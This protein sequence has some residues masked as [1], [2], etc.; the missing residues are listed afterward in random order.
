LL[1]HSILTAML[2][3]DWREEAFLEGVRHGVEL[4]E[5][6]KGLFAE[7]FQFRVRSILDIRLYE[8]GPS[9]LSGL[10]IGCEIAEALRYGF[11]RHQ[12]ITVIGTEHLAGRYQR[13]LST[14]GFD[15]EMV[16]GDLAAK[17]LYRLARYGKLI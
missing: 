17:G 11:D 14:A 10:L 12:K 2:D 7:L 16:R 3:E 13:A 6:N 4:A 8:D 5:Q 9:R 1:K 15:A